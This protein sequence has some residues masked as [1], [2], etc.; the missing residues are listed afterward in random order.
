MTLIPTIIL[1]TLVLLSGAITIRAI[2]REA[3]QQIHLFKPLTTALILAI[4]LFNSDPVSIT[5]KNLI[6]AGLVASLIGDVALMLPDERWFLYGLLS[7][8]GAHVV[9]I[10]AFTMENDGMAAWYYA[11]PFG[12]FALLMLFTLWPHLGSMRGP[13]FVYMVVIMFMAWQAASRW[14]NNPDVRSTQL[15]LAGA[16]LFV[17]SDSVLAIQRFRGTW[18]SA[19]FWVMSTYYTAQWLIALSV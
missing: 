16:Y 17:A 14:L 11:V 19:S 6:A 15:A 3:D 7:F 9:Y 10:T 4:A 13:V 12:L 5:Y 1:S 2:Y 18:R 8:L